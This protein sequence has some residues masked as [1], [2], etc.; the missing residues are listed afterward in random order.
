MASPEWRG[1]WL[2]VLRVQLF[3]DSGLQLVHPHPHL[4][5]AKDQLQQSQ[6]ED[7][8]PSNSFLARPAFLGLA[9]KPWSITATEAG[10][11]AINP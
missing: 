9:S 2:V 4:G 7:Q 5:N 11:L 3:W 1:E 8:F 10:R 6:V